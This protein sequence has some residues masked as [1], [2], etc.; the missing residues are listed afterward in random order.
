MGARPHLC[1]RRPTPKPSTLVS[2]RNSPP[3]RLAAHSLSS[4]TGPLFRALS[5]LCSGD[6]SQHP[7]FT[8]DGASRLW[9][10]MLGLY[11]S[12]TPNS[13]PRFSSS[14]G[15]LALVLESGDFFAFVSA[16]LCIPKYVFLGFSSVF[17]YDLVRKNKKSPA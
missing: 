5:E 7:R 12:K 8:A 4:L 1:H 17:L 11:L 15:A 10:A 2:P 16:Q 14:L 3:L 6:Q 9:N 13:Q